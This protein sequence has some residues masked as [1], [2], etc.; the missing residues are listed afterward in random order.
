MREAIEDKVLRLLCL[1]HQKVPAVLV[2]NKMDSIP[3]SRRVFDLIRKLTCNRLD[4]GSG[5][6]KIAPSDSKFSMEKYLRRKEQ[7]L[8]KREAESEVEKFGDILE[9]ARSERLSEERCSSLT[10]GLVG[11]PGFRDV[12]TVSALQGDGVEDLR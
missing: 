2:L 12:F 3:K 1:Y 10:A 5:V 4:D 7:A 8:T 11:W 6:V 9:I